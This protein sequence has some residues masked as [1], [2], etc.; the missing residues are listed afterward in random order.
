MVFLD[1]AEKVGIFNDREIYLGQL[2]CCPSPRHEVSHGIKL[3]LQLLWDGLLGILLH[4]SQ[5]Y[6]VLDQLWQY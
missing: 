4:S 5:S 3:K 2:T 6:T 1:E